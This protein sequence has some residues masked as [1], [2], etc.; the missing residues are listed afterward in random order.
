MASAALFMMAQTWKEIAVS[1]G[2]SS[3][4]LCNSQAKEKGC[5]IGGAL[6]TLKRVDGSAQPVPSTRHANE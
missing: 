1:G 4:K 5:A 3:K 6:L 2:M